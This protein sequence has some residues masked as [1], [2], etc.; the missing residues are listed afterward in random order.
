MANKNGHTLP[1]TRKGIGHYKP[2]DVLTEGVGR[3]VYVA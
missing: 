3:D 1:V 2:E